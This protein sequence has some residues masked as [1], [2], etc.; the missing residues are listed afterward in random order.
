MKEFDDHE[1]YFTVM[2]YRVNTYIRQIDCET[3]ITIFNEQHGE[4]W[5]SIE[6]RIFE[7]C[8]KIF[9]SATVEE[10]PF[11]IGSC[12]SSRASYATDLILELKHNNNKIQPKLLEINFAPNCQHAC[13]SYSTFYY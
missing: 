10:P 3:F 4:I 8:R 11:D 2:D 5:L 7:L 1:T 9:Y 13:T 6:Q 12:L